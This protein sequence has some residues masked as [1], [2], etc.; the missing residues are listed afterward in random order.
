MHFEDSKSAAEAATEAA[1]KAIAAAEFAAYMA[2]KD[3][4]EASQ[5]YYND[6]FYNDPAKHTHN[7]AHKSTTEE[8]MHRSHSLPRSDHIN[9]EDILYGGKDYRRHSYHPASAHSAASVHSDIKFDESDCDEEIEAEEPPITLPPKRLPP[10]VPSSVVKQDSNI[11][12]HPKL[13]DYD[14]LT[15]RFDALKFKKSQ[16]WTLWATTYQNVLA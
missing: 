16:P 7:L 8:K 14:E 2:M 4:N 15:A 1:K 9:N 13:P 11:R 5:P 10:P 6:K 3:S 12:V